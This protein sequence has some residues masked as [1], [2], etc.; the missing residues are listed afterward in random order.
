[1]QPICVFRPTTAPSSEA[2]STNLRNRSISSLNGVPNSEQG[3]TSVTTLIA[4][5]NLQQAEKW[6]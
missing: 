1:M 2:I 3:I 4:L 6:S 5:A